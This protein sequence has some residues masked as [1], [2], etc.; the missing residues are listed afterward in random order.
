[1]FSGYQQ[2]ISV[3]TSSLIFPLRFYGVIPVPSNKRCFFTGGGVA[4]NVAGYMTLVEV[5]FTI[6]SV[7]G[8]D[9]FLYGENPLP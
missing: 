7:T 5:D 8:G 2:T 4:G 9:G 3:A 6:L 1:M